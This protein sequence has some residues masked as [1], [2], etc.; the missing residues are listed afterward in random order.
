MTLPCPGRAV[1]AM[2]E[3]GYEAMNRS[4]HLTAASD[5]FFLAS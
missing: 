3:T 5:T 2:S 4:I 1:L